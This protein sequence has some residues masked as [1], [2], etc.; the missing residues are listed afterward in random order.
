MQAPWF[1]AF[2]ETCQEAADLVKP[3]VRMGI[4]ET[5]LYDKCPYYE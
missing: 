2:A 3:I 1:R 5:S 4:R